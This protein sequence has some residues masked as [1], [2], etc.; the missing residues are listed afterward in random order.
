MNTTISA[1]IFFVTLLV[2]IHIRHYYTVSS[3]YEMIILNNIEHLNTAKTF[4]RLLEDSG[5][6]KLPCL[7]KNT[8]SLDN[9]NTIFN[10]QLNY[11]NILELFGEL[12][13][14]VPFIY[15]ENI[16]DKHTKN[17]YLTIEASTF[18]KND[19]DVDGRALLFNDKTSNNRQIADDKQRRLLGA[20]YGCVDTYAN[21]YLYNQYISR[22][23]HSIYFSNYESKTYVEFQKYKNPLNVFYVLEGKCDVV[24]AHSDCIKEDLIKD[25]YVFFKFYYD[26]NVFENNN[27]K[28]LT[29]E[30]KD[31]L[32]IIQCTR[33][34]VILLP[35]NWYISIQLHNGCVILNESVSTLT[36][37]VSLAPDY[38]KNLMY[39]STI[40]MVPNHISKVHE[41][42]NDK[43]AE[44]NDIDTNNTSTADD[45]NDGDIITDKTIV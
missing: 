24:V 6:A 4:D 42:E 30:G 8:D 9:L 32:N 45:E 16:S 1:I 2:Y 12:K 13:L 29:R 15:D 14:C 35:N 44:I 34:D 21:K 7:F 31:K 10:V 3:D 5:R 38:L 39:R 36:S 23:S 19:V 37:V 40:K 33:G 20:I 18:G 25:D 22:K 27:L 26:K 41:D 17:I 28:H 11:T 43:G